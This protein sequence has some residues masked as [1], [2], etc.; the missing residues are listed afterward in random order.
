MGDL[1][2]IGSGG[3]PKPITEKMRIASDIVDKLIDLIDGKSEGDFD[4]E[5]AEWV[6][7][8]FIQTIKQDFSDA[9]EPRF[10]GL[11]GRTGSTQ[12]M[13]ARLNRLIGRF[14]RWNE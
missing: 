8:M 4:H 1:I 9:D 7:A 6:A 11:E 5:V 3:S 10:D 2:D 12:D 13:L 14:E